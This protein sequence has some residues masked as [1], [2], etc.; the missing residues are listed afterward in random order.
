M[1]QETY[2]EGCTE[3][4]SAILNCPQCGSRICIKCFDAQNRICKCCHVELSKM[5]A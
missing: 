5:G 4:F 2:C 3:E 1:S